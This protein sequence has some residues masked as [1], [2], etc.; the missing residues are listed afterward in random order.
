[1]SNDRRGVKEGAQEALRARLERAL[2]TLDF[3]CEPSALGKTLGFNYVCR[4][5]I[6]TFIIQDSLRDVCP[7]SKGYYHTKSS[8]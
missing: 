1:M 5:L 4:D 8:L 2:E 3:G 7:P 6:I